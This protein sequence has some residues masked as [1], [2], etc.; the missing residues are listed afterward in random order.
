MRARHIASA[1]PQRKLPDSDDPFRPGTSNKQYNK[2]CVSGIPKIAMRR[3]C[4]RRNQ[5]FPEIPC[6]LHDRGHGL[7][8]SSRNKKR[9]RGMRC[10]GSAIRRRTP[11]SVCAPWCCSSA[12]PMVRIVSE[13]VTRRPD[14]AEYDLLGRYLPCRSPIPAAAYGSAPRR[15]EWRQHRRRLK[16]RLI[17][18]PPPGR[19]RTD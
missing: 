8:N 17:R 3:G 9:P 7:T 18:R 16:R 11:T 15:Y 13:F 10:H 1:V 2:A 19:H 5:P 4:R 6:R 14:R 12:A